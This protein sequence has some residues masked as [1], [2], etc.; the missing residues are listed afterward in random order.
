MSPPL[1]VMLTIP[2]GRLG[3]C[4]QLY[5]R[6]VVSCGTEACLRR[7]MQPAE[8]RQALK[9][10]TVYYMWYFALGC[11]I[12]SLGALLPGI[13]RQTGSTPDQQKWFVPP[14]ATGFGVGSVVGG[15]LL[16]RFDGHRLMAVAAAATTAVN[17]AMATAGSFELVLVLQLCYGLLGGGSEDVINTLTLQVWGEHVGPYM[18][19]LHACFALGTVVGPVVVGAVLQLSG[20][21][22][23]PAFAVFAAF[24]VP[25]LP[26]ALL[27]R[28]PSPRA[29]AAAADRV[30][31]GAT[32]GVGGGAAA[33][34]AR[35][36]YVV[37]VL[38]TLQLFLGVGA[39]IGFGTW[40]ATYAIERLAVSEVAAAYISSV[41]YAGFLAG[42]LAA[43]PVSARLRPLSLLWAGFAVGA[44]A[45]MPLLPGLSLPGPTVPVL[46]AVSA[47]VGFAIAPIFAS[48]MSV[49]ST[50]RL[51]LRSWMLSFQVSG[52]VCGE[53]LVTLAVGAAMAGGRVDQ[54]AV[55][56]FAT[57][58]AGL[59]VCAALA[60]ASRAAAKLLPPSPAGG[61]PTGDGEQQ[62]QEQETLISPGL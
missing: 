7:I 37:M 25:S 51:P 35:L 45:L 16:E 12:S 24:T 36:S 39:E 14:R 2:R 33:R 30:S 34:L 50:A 20:G 1:A 10:S 18:Q 22:V 47:V 31:K 41:Y 48:C 42:R 6:R 60:A 11:T 17:L 26:L 28:T 21:T 44:V 8:R 57:M 53:M 54:F 38:V 46:A 59:A 58:C 62:V 43:V 19:L 55:L 9:V 56:T 5:R 23:A 49:G 61:G 52:A 3:G 4:T 27:V 15:M 32:S 29:P 40:I 13:A